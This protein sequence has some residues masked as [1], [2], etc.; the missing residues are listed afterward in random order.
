MHGAEVK[1]SVMARLFKMVEAK[2]ERGAYVGR[3]GRCTW[4]PGRRSPEERV[5]SGEIQLSDG[6]KTGGAVWTG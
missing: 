5:A 1:D 3:R 4:D 6:V 2:A